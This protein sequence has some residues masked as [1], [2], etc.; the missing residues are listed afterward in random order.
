ELDAAGLTAT[1]MHVGY[2][3][4]RDNLEAVL[5]EAEILGASRIGVAWI[6]HE[7]SYT[8]ETAR[9]TAA[10]FNQWG[11]AVAARG[12]RFYYHT[13]GY[14]FEPAADGT[15]PFDVLVEATDP[16]S[17]GFEMDVFWVTHPGVDPAALLRKYPDRWELMHIKD[18]TKGTP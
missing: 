12:Y 9:A 16:A 3:Q 18:M 2:E 15:V 5:N 7:G 8:P 17:V 11:Q 6:P 13:H 4:M 1:A 10:D 14:G